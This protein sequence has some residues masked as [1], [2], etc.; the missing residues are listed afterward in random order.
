MEMTGGRRAVAQEDVKCLSTSV[1]S[2]NALGLARMSTAPSSR[3]RCVSSVSAWAERMTT[4]RSG[5]RLRMRERTERPSSPGMTRSRKTPS[6]VVV[7]TTLSAS[8][9]SSATRT[10]CPSTRKTSA[11]TWATEGSSS[12]TSIRMG[13]SAT[14]VSESH[15]AL[16]TNHHTPPHIPSDTI[17][18]IGSD[19]QTSDLL[20]RAVKEI[21]YSTVVVGNLPDA[22]ALVPSLRPQ[23]IMLDI[24]DAEPGVL[25]LLHQLR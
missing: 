14:A 17:L 18:V 23:A 4:G 20:A 16:A 5:N 21:G 2:R 13:K 19:L 8:T 22:L 6:T 7:S 11:R 9:P 12:S 10:S 15:L 25:D 24:D 1:R 3:A